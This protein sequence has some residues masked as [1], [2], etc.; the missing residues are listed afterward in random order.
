[1]VPLGALD[2]CRATTLIGGRLGFI[3]TPLVTG[4]SPSGDADLDSALVESVFP[5]LFINI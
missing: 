2:G 1:M 5:L 3:P 4:F